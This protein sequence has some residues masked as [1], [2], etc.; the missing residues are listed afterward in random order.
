MTIKFC[1][2]CGSEMKL[3]E[4]GAM[5]AT[6]AIAE[7]ARAT[8]ICTECAAAG[9]AIDWCEI[10]REAWREGRNR[11]GDG[12]TVLHPTDYRVW[13]GIGE[14]SNPGMV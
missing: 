11:G 10:V 2:I 4:A 7:M 12:G 8:N 14:L 1:D 5:A 13:N 3:S 6:G 9:R